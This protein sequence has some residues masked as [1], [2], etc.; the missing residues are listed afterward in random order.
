M[1][2]AAAVIALLAAVVPAQVT[3]ADTRPALPAAPAVPRVLLTPADP[4]LPIDL[5]AAFSEFDR[6]NNRLIFRQ[7]TITQGALTIRADEATAD[8]ADFEN[9]VWIFTGDVSIN[10]A[11]TQANCDRAELSFRSNRLRKAALTGTPARFS[12]A[13]TNGDPAT[14][15]RALLL[16]YDFET[17]TIQLTTDAFLSDGKSEISGS[18]IAYDLQSEIVTAGGT[19]GG[20]VR[21]RITP[22]KKPSPPAT[23]P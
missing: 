15:G 6:R 10:N 4:A 18:R 5:D 23:K 8:P 17:A 19:P 12:Q 3:A 14:E 16:D 2:F 11:G 20:E 7:L 9:S 22:E 21:M 1:T 13:G